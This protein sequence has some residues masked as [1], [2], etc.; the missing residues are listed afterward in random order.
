MKIKKHLHLAYL[1]CFFFSI[2]IYF[3]G[4]FCF[5]SFILDIDECATNTHNCGVNAVCTNTPGSHNCTCKPGYAGDGKKCSGN[6]YFSRVIIWGFMKTSIFT[7]YGLQFVFCFCGLLQALWLHIC[8][9]N[10]KGPVFHNDNDNSIRP[11][12]S[13]T[14]QAENLWYLE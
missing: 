12:C 7:F 10:I 8:M 1:L 9:Y 14:V 5:F 2:L 13:T 4:I 6:F 3:S 11:L